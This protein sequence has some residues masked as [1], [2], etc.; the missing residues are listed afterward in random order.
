MV[1]LLNQ[2]ATPFAKLINQKEDNTYIMRLVQ[3]SNALSP[4]VFYYPFT[5]AWLF[6]LLAIVN[7]EKFLCVLPKIIFYSSNILL[8][9][10]A[11]IR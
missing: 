2:F 1:L 7:N 9:H 8:H 10:A 3:V 11:R 4:A 5:D 6:V